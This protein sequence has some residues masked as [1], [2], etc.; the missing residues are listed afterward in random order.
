YDPTGAMYGDG[1][2]WENDA[3]YVLGLAVKEGHTFMESPNTI[4]IKRN[5]INTSADVFSFSTSGV[6]TEKGNTEL[7]KDQIDRIMAVPNPYFGAN[8]YERNQFGK[9]IRF[10][11]LPKQATL[12]IFNL[13][14]DMVRVIEKDD[15]LTTADWDLRNKNDLPIASGMYI[16]YIDMPDIGTKILKVAVIMSE[17]RLDNF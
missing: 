3:I 10:T 16:V 12:R 8:A 5:V 9:I 7:A 6:R 4:S 2:T 14:S 11:N 17:E 1:G 13:A 15:N